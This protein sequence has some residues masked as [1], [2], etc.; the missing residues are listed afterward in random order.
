MADMKFVEL[1]D[2]E[3]GTRFAIDIQIIDR[4]L[5]LVADSDVEADEAKSRIVTNGDNS[6]V[7]VTETYDEVMRQI[8]GL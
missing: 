1:H 3:D 6:D 7:E 5:E 2:A 4:V 8:K